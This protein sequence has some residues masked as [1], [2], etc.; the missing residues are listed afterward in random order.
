MMDFAVESSAGQCAL[1]ATRLGSP[2]RA[3][4]V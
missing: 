4:F 2:V 1:S 3:I